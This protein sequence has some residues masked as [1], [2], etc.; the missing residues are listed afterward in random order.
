MSPFFPKTATSTQAVQHESKSSRTLTT[1]MMVMF[2]FG[3]LDL[4]SIV[5]VGEGFP[6]LLGKFVLVGVGIGAM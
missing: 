4:G 1:I 2:L 3:T 6:Q 5:H